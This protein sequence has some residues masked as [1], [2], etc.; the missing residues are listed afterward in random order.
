VAWLRRLHTTL[1]PRRPRWRPRCNPRPLHVVLLVVDKVQLAQA[2]L[3]E[4]PLAVAL[5]P[6]QISYKEWPGTEPGDKKPKTKMSFPANRDTACKIWGC[7]SGITEDSGLLKCVAV[8]TGRV[9]PTFRRIVAPLSSDSSDRRIILGPPD[10]NS[11]ITP[12]SWIR[13]HHDPSKRR[14]LLASDTASYPRRSDSTNSFSLPTHQTNSN[15][16]KTLTNKHQ[17]IFWR[18]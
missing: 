4:T 11:S 2:F 15:I 6:T 3:G 7:H 17:N 5:D 10:T 14:H 18:V 9:V 8:G 13:R 1:S 16:Q 12:V